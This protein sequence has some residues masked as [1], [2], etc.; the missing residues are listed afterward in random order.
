[1]HSSS[2]QPIS[3]VGAQPSLGGHNFRLGGTSSHLGGTAPECPPRGA[4][5]VKKAGKWSYQLDQSN[6]TGKNAQLMVYVRNEGDMDLEEEFLFCTPL[7]TTTTGADIFK[8]GEASSYDYVQKIKYNLKHIFTKFY[9][10]MICCFRDILFQ[11]K[12]SQQCCQLK[13]HFS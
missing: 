6:D 7:T 4:G 9:Q 8:G 10:L 3:F 5:P 2:P 12:I 11:S 1:M 13:F